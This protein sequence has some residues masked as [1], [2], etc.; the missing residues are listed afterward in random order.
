V[1]LHTHQDQLTEIRAITTINKE[2]NDQ[3]DRLI[4][5][6]NGKIDSLLKSVEILKITK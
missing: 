5:M 6:N 4:D 2:V 3:Q 1:T